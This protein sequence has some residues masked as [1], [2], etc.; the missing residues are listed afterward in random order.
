MVAHVTSETHRRN[1]LIRKYPV[2]EKMIQEMR[3]SEINDR[4]ME[5]ETKTGGREE[6]CYEEIKSSD[7]QLRYDYLQSSIKASQ[8]TNSIPSLKKDKIPQKVEYIEHDPWNDFTNFSN[9]TAENKP[10]KEEI[11]EPIKT[12]FKRPMID[13]RDSFPTEYSGI[14]SNMDM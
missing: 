8:G 6:R 12:E 5:E 4:A 2:L 7:D 13:E 11:I 9:N 3:T 14:G 1:Q 10:W